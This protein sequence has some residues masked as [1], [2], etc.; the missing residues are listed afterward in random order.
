MKGKRM[1]DKSTGA[2][3]RACFQDMGDL[4]CGD[5]VM[6]ILKTLRPLQPGDVMEIWSRAPLPRL[7]AKPCGKP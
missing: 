2:L 3:P 4:S 7:P 1:T 5:L 6:A